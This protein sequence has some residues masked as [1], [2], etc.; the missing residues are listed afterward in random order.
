MAHE[1]KIKGSADF[2]SVSR[3]VQNLTKSIKSALPENGVQFIDAGSMKFLKTEAVQTF[4][5][6]KNHI[7]AIKKEASD[8]DSILK[9]SKATEDEKARAA[10]NRLRLIQAELRLQKELSQLEKQA[11][12]SGILPTMPSNKPIPVQRGRASAI[13]ARVAGGVGRF[14]G[15]LPEVGQ[16]GTIAKDSLSAG[17]NTAQKVGGKAGIVAGIALAGFTAAIGVATL[18]VSRMSK[19]VAAFRAT[20]NARLKVE[21][22]DQGGVSRRGLAAGARMGFSDVAQNIETQGALSQAFGSASSARVAGNRMEN[23]F[24]ASRMFGMDPSE[25][26]GAGNQLRAAGGTATASKQMALIL[27]RAVTSGMDKSQVSTYLAETSALISEMNKSGIANMDQMVSLM[28]DLSSSGMF[29]PEQAAKTIKSMQEAIS[30][31]SGE[32]Q[33]FFMHAAQA[34]GLGGKSI[35]GTELAVQQ[36]LVGLDPKKIEELTKGMS[37]G[38]DIKKFLTGAGLLDENF[39][40]KMA[41]GINKKLDIFKG[42]PAARMNFVQQKFGTTNAADTL[43]VMKILEKLEK[44]IASPEDKTFMEKMGGDP[45]KE[46]REDVRTQL[47]TIAG[48]AAAWEGIKNLKQVEFGAAA[49]GVISSMEKIMIGFDSKVQEL[50]GF[51]NDINSIPQKISSGLSEIWTNLKNIPA[52][53]GKTFSD[54]L[55]NPGEFAE[56]IG[57]KVGEALGKTFK[58]GAE[59]GT[60]IANAVA[61]AFGEGGMVRQMASAIKQGLSDV[62]S[63]FTN[64]VKTMMVTLLEALNSLPMMNL[65]ETIKDFKSSMEDVSLTKGLKKGFSSTAPS[66]EEVEGLGKALKNAGSS[67][68]GA[69]SKAIEEGK[70]LM[71]GASLQKQDELIEAVREGVNAQKS[72]EK[73]VLKEIIPGISNGGGTQ[74]G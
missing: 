18:A 74:L 41:A 70:T 22:F 3:G 4:Q 52:E 15:S 23:T 43:K 45:E 6:V 58:L 62:I 35:Y 46:W 55:K 10:K 16:F 66:Q 42:N 64:I 40:Q 17:S 49:Q 71:Q 67:I 60:D 61:K 69:G 25:I 13:G 19:A 34:G 44:G 28:A 9:S 32:N 12:S 2:T 29:S 11:Q 26:T 54:I 50:L 48:A 51:V 7:S 20:L 31:S 5:K 36:G 37:G 57:Q 53:I 59:L 21:A 14:G 39:G 27:S 73:K 72:I 38:S 68:M 63:G 8:L 47:K 56:K 24:M 1:I 65:D 33:A 30:G